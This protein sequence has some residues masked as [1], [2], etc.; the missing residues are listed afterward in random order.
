[1]Q[2]RLERPL[3]HSTIKAYMSAISACHKGWGR[4]WFSTSSPEIFPASDEAEMCGG[5]FLSGSVRG[6]FKAAAQVFWA[7]LI[8][9]V[10]HRD[11]VAACSVV[12]VHV[13]SMW[14]ACCSEQT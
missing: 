7:D 6:P 3:S 8:L 2:L 10:V 13:W 9:V 4:D 11:S 1:M 12:D 14:A 5:A